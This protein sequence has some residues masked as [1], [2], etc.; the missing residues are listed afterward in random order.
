MATDIL[1]ASTENIYCAWLNDKNLMAESPR[2]GYVPY[3]SDLQ[4]PGDRRRL[5]SWAMDAGIALNTK[6]P[7]ESDL[8]VLSNAANFGYW[9]KRAQQPVILD[10]VDGYLGEHP[11]FIKDVTRNIV[12]SIRG[13]S[14][15]RWLTYTNH[16]RYAC[17]KSD[18]VIVASAEQR[19]IILEFNKNV[20][21]ILDDLSELSSIGTISSKEF[22]GSVKNAPS[23]WIFWEGF[24]FTLKHFQAIS[25]D[26]D[27]FLYESGW[28]MN[29]VTNIEFPRWGGYIGKV[30]TRSLIDKWFP[31][32]SQHIKIIPWSLKNV[33]E[34][35][36]RSSLSIIPIDLDDNFALLKPENKLLS[37]WHLGLP[38]L[39]S[40]IPSY[41]RVA[42][43]SK[44]EASMVSPSEWLDA[45]KRI[46]SSPISRDE[47][48]KSGNVYISNNNS[49]E[50]L[51]AKWA[52]VI[53]EYVT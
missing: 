25:K 11:K 38:T 32:S 22:A 4:H 18:L 12:R 2:V 19:E 23:E 31:L 33:T 43:A 49:H 39:F 30:K 53:H 21:V 13:S 1:V 41:Q 48:K 46:A 16:L 7:L 10:L 5:A 35:A 8:L 26:L 29:L 51:G 34:F 42:I 15:L 27:Q 36:Q 3:S 52:K 20:H 9:L 44:Q 24:G 28:G 37:M 47:M 17:E 14:D 50:V 6:D 40:P 45:L